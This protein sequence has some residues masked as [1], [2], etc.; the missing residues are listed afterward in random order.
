VVPLGQVPYNST[1]TGMTEFL[2]VTISMVARKGCDY[3]LFDLI[4]ALESSGI[5]SSV[6]VGKTAFAV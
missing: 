3:M 5:I 2:P 6:G 4:S 1:I